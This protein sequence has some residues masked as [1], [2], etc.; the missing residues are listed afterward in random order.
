MMPITLQATPKQNPQ[1]YADGQQYNIRVWWDGA[2]MMFLDVTINGTVV[3]TSLPCIVGQMVMPYAFMEGAGGNF[4]WQ[5]ASG[6]NPIYTNFGTNDILLY[7]SAA[8]MAAVREQ[9]NV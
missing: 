3:A 5:T 8:E 4:F 9:Y 2:D 7:A 1:F 6:D